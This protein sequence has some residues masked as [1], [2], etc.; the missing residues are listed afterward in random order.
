MSITLAHPNQAGAGKVHAAHPQRP[1]PGTIPSHSRGEQL[2][3]LEYKKV[4][5]QL[6]SLLNPDSPQ[7][8]HYLPLLNVLGLRRPDDAVSFPVSGID[9]GSVS[10]RTVRFG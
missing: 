6:V 1:V 2:V 8:E 4:Y 9:G 3:T 5:H 7:A 10:M